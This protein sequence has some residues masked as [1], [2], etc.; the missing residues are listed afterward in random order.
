MNFKR[1]L[2]MEDQGE[3]F[4]AYRSALY[5]SGR[6]TDKVRSVSE[7]VKKLRESENEYTAIIFDLKVLPGND[8]G[9]IDF[10]Q[11]QKKTN[12]SHDPCLG[13]ELLR[14]LFAPD[15]AGI[16]LDPPISI[17][18]KKM[19]VFSAIP[20]K[21]QEIAAMGIPEGR[22]IYKSDCDLNTLPDLIDKIE[23]ESQKS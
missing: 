18:P 12:P 22:I 9:W 1:I 7:A 6:M 21:E 17:S 23:E 2:W 14:S 16:K 10:D 19:I 13:L 3:D 4:T 11:R 5:R 8:P 15:Q 20:G